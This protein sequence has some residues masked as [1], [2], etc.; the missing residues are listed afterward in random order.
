MPISARQ[1]RPIDLTK[2]CIAA[3]VLL[4]V[5][6]PLVTGMGIFFLSQLLL[7]LRGSQQPAMSSMQWFGVWLLLTLVTLVLG[8]TITT[9]RLRA[10][11]TQ[12]HRSEYADF[13]LIRHARHGPL[14]RPRRSAVGDLE[15][16]SFGLRYILSPRRVRHWWP[17]FNPQKEPE[18]KTY[19]HPVLLCALP[20]P[21]PPFQ[22]W[23]TSRRWDEPIAQKIIPAIASGPSQLSGQFDFAGDKRAV[24]FF[25]DQRLVELLLAHADWNIEVIGDRLLAFRIPAPEVG[26]SIGSSNPAPADGDIQFVARLAQHLSGHE[27]R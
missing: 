12:P 18:L 20:A 1:I 10:G 11:R 21:L 6:V 2:E 9:L 4:V 13:K 16:V 3:A 23:S 17:L 5:C 7:V 8:M 15:L 24:A 26:K 22:L 14:I 27:G 25:S 19:C